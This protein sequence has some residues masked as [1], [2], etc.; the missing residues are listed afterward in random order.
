MLQVLNAASKPI[1]VE[2]QT[3]L[4]A[5]D[6]VAL[7]TYGKTFTTKWVTVHDT[8]VDGNAPFNANTLAKAAHGTPFK[9]PENGVFRPGHE[10]RRVLLHETGDTNSTSVENDTAGGWGVVFKLVQSGPVG[11]HGEALGLLQGQPDA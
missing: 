10:V 7:H 5:P 11:R 1:T 6:Q 2:S 4:N 8:A 3:A 9:R